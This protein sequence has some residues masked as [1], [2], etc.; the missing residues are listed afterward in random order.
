MIW[1]TYE[2]NGNNIGHVVMLYVEKVG[3][4]IQLII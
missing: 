4:Y 3:L 2:E 1:L